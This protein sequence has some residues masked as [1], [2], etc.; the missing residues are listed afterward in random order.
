MSIPEN[1]PPRAL[2]VHL[3]GS[4]ER[5][6]GE[7]CQHPFISQTARLP[8]CDGPAWVPTHASR[9]RL[10]F[11]ATKQSLTALSLDVGCAS[12]RPR[13]RTRLS[14]AALSRDRLLGVGD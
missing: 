6:H 11:V 13:C 3:P 5:K 9:N 1:R 10:F 8:S 12:R 14:F 4:L 7:A 2:L